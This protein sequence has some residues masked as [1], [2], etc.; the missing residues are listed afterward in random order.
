MCDMTKY[1]NN[2]YSTIRV[3]AAAANAASSA[4]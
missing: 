1:C 4:Q 3:K 2:Y